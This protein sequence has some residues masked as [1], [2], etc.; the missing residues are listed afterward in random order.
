M[1]DFLDG[2]LG[3][4]GSVSLSDEEFDSIDLESQ[5]YSSE[6]YEALLA[7]VNARESVST[8]SARLKS[9]FEARGVT[10]SDAVEAQSNI[11]IGGALCE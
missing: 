11:L 5:T 10:I 1:R 2:I 7:V 9:Y 3:F 8:A 6:T 4:I